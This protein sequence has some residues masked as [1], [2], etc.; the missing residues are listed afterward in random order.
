M[1]GRRNKPIHSTLCIVAQ[2]LERVYKYYY[3]IIQGVNA[4]MLKH[5]FTNPI[6]PGF[7]PDPSILRVEDDYYLIQSSFGLFPGIRCSIRRIL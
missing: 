6:I 3:Y 1:Y 5:T 2:T 7:Y 4:S